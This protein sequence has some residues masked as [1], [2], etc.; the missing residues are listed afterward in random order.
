MPQ[1]QLHPPSDERGIPTPSN[2]VVRAQSSAPSAEEI[3]F[4][5]EAVARSSVIDWIENLRPQ[6]ENSDWG[7][8]L[9]LDG[10]SAVDVLV[11]PIYLSMLE[12]LR[13]GSSA[14]PT[15]V[16]RL[17]RIRQL[18]YLVKVACAAVI[19]RTRSAQPTQ[20]D[21]LFWPRDITHIQGQMPVA[22]VMAQSGKRIAFFACQPRIQHQLERQG[23]SVVS[24]FRAW[25]MRL[26]AAHR[27]GSQR[28]RALR[29]APASPMCSVA[30][31]D[32]DGTLL[33]DALRANLVKY[34][35]LACEAVANARA[36]LERFDPGM[37]VVGND[38]TFE[39]RAGAL[40]A[41]QVGIP[42]AVLMHGSFAVNDIQR[43]H[44]ADKILVYGETYRDSLLNEGI[45]DS[46]IEVTGAPYLD[47][48]PPQQGSVN[49]VIQRRLG[50]ASDAPV[51]LVATSG[52]GH[53]VSMQHHQFVIEQIAKLSAR[54]PDLTFL[55]K[56]HRKDR[57]DHY[58]P[59][60]AKVP[61]SK[62]HI[63]PHGE[64]G[65]PHSIFDWLQGC[66]M[67]LTGSSTVA[68]EAMI[69]NV[70]VVTMDF[71]G[72][73]SGVEFIEAGATVHVTTPA[74][75]E[76]AVRNLV[77]TPQ[78]YH[79][80]RRNAQA[81]IKSAFLAVDGHSAERAAQAV[82]KMSTSRTTRAL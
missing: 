36:A 72:E 66:R 15:S 61:Y 21:A 40:A 60:L 45:A 59:I 69:Q 12:L 38:L 46:R 33:A 18:A 25:P 48:I 81:Y 42:T 53:V 64:R 13:R 75:L 24:P 9:N 26:R 14:G 19:A 51:I 32:L 47:A 6:I 56:L 68:L 37:L 78:D 79:Q 23:F 62:L 41:R 1:N 76:L 30:G 55:I 73:I 71:A 82:A 28:A 16:G 8:I 34:L 5:R 10:I 49:Q 11:S 54:L 63:V 44:V 65:Y 50:I 7:D 3:T 17:K 20:V 39:G 2:Y 35:P 52:P 74:E 58:R 57:I 4:S 43:L 29:R 31:T 77:R 70:P 27:D 67:L 80:T 22:S